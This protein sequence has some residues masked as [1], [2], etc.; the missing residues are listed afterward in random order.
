M[1]K[2]GGVYYMTIPGASVTWRHRHRR[3]PRPERHRVG[4]LRVT[5]KWLELGWDAHRNL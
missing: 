3:H 1:E 2:V 4:G 5:T